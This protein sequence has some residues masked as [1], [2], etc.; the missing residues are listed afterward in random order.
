MF[1][2]VRQVHVYL[3]HMWWLVVAER[4]RVEMCFCLGICV[5][6]WWMGRWLNGLGYVVCPRAWVCLHVHIKVR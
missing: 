1:I 3:D 4:V 2:N 6:G 5:W